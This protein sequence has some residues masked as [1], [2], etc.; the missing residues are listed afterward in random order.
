MPIKRSGRGQKANKTST[1]DDITLASSRATSDLKCNANAH[2]CV[3]IRTQIMGKDE[4][5]VRHIQKT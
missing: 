5:L 2:V 3:G 1:L 4:M